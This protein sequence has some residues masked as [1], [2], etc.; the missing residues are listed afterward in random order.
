MRRTAIRVL[1]RLAEDPASVTDH[2]RSLEEAGRI[3]VDRG[4]T[5]NADRIVG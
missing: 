3:E 4:G 2:L 1:E 5:L